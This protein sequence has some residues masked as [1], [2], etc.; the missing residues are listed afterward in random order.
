VRT[1]SEAA[2][3]LRC[4]YEHFGETAPRLSGDNAVVWYFENA[5]RLG[6]LAF[7]FEEASGN[8][9]TQPP[10][11]FEDVV[12]ASLVDETGLTGLVVL[13]EVLAPVVAATM[14]AGQGKAVFEDIVTSARV[15]ARSESVENIAFQGEIVARFAGMVPNAS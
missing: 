8:V 2:A 9:R 3:L 5:R 15:L 4:L 12:R 14:Q 7:A 1:P 13:C 6:A 11:W 10:T